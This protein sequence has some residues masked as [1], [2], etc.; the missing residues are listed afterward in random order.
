MLTECSFNR[1]IITRCAFTAIYSNTSNK[2]FNV[3][4]VSTHRQENIQHSGAQMLWGKVALMPCPEHDI[5]VYACDVQSRSYP[6]IFGSSL[7][8]LCCYQLPAA[9]TQ[10]K[11]LC[12]HQLLVAST[13]GKPLFCYQLPSASTHGKPLC[14][15]RLPSASTQGKP[16]CC[17]QLS[18]VST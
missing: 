1:I 10:G 4:S 15:H 11:P 2:G 17:H 8:V 5:R 12:C 18:A 7:L 9:A 16:L 13:Q 6:Q 3:N 14:C